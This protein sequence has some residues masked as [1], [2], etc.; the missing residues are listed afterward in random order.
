MLQLHLFQ[1]NLQLFGDQHWDGGIG[2]LAHLDIGHGQ[3]DLPV[4]SDADEG[5]RREAVRRFGNAVCERQAQTQHQASACSR[6]SL[7]EPAPR[8]TVRWRPTRAG[9]FGSEVIVS[10]C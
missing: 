8:N 7:Q 6:S 5:I 9:G 1:L 4:A 3:D 2:A 10:H